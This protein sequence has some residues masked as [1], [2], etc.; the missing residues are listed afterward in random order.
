MEQ[1]T[2]TF[3]FKNILSNAVKYSFKSADD[4]I[5]RYIEVICKLI[6]MEKYKITITNYGIGIEKSEIEKGMIWKLGWRGKLTRD[7][8]RMGLGFGLSFTK[9]IIEEV[10][11]GSITAKSIQL[12]KGAYLT[13]FIITLPISL[14]TE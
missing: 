4:K 7:R 11:K 5:K 9:K 12:Y 14:H 3:A 8:N 6:G 1:D 2:L 13:S 10:H